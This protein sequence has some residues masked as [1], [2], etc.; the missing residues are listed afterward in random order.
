MLIRNESH[1][2]RTI[3][4]KLVFDDD[5]RRE[6][7]LNEGDCVQVSYRKNGGIKVGVGIIKEISPYMKKKWQ[8]NNC[9]IKEGA[10]ITLDMS[11]DHVAC[12][13]RFDL[14]DICD[15]RKVKVEEVEDTITDSDF[16][17]C[18][19]PCVVGCPV[20][21]KGVDNSECD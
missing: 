20:K 16:T 19:S 10:V 5:T 1:I 2:I 6:L 9:C 12:V 11:E 13:D 21:N 14:Y 17:V 4:I 3:H 7:I 15:I 8:L 18:K